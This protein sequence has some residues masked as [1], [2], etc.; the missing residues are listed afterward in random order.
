[1]PTASATEVKID[2]KTVKLTNL[3]KLMW[4]EG[5][6]KAHLVQYYTDIAPYL[7]PH[8]QGRPLVMKRY[9]DGITGESFYQKECPTYAPEWVQR[10]PI[11]HSDKPVNYIICDITA[12]LV[13]LANQGCIEIHS[14]LSTREALDYPDIAIIDLDPGDNATFKDVLLVAGVTKQ[15]LDQL[16]LSG[17]PKTSGAT[18]VHILIPIKPVYTFNEVTKA[19]GFVAQLVTQAYSEK[20]TI[21]RTLEKRPKNKVYVDYLQ[22]TRGKS[23]SCVY[24][25]R[26]LPGAPVSAPLFWEE[27]NSLSIRPSDFNI[28]SIFERLS[29]A[30]ELHA[31]ISSN[32]QDLSRILELAQ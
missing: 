22:N 6:T 28:K 18:G 21:E 4:P 15:A 3:G 20:A 24:S 2:D 9:P 1:M 13:W 30:G 27:I 14:W 16:G 31:S 12:T 25:L 11:T 23:M 10:Q 7:L 29:S 32:R 19:M 8:I 5:L 17:Y 26:P